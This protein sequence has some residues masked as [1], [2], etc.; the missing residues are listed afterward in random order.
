VTT[1]GEWL[2][3]GPFDLALSSGFFGF[4]AHAGLVQTLEESRLRPAGLSGSSAG[5][6]V[7]GLWAAGMSADAI[8]GELL[9]LRRE[10]FWDPRLGLGLL[11]GRK[12]RERLETLLPATT[13]DG[14]QAR[15]AVSVFDV[16]GR[17]TRV[18]AD[19][20]LAPAIHASCAVPGLFHPVWLDGRPHID[21]GLFD[22]PG[23][24]GAA[25]ARV[26]HHHLVPGRIPRRDGLVSLVVEDVPRTGPFRLEAG[27]RA[28]ARVQ[29]AARRALDAP[30]EGGVVR[31]A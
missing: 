29:T 20:R 26:L 22:R 12:F 24:V 28:L 9:S 11:A 2:A 19:G 7:A 16:L 25:G 5:A 23:L 27:A 10:D 3:R 14:C 8:G 6:L 15:L 21:G 4:F 1:L 13:F 31:I 17:R 30:V 18:I